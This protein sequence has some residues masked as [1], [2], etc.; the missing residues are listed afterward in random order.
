MRNTAFALAIA[1]AFVATPVFAQGIAPANADSGFFV[2]ANG[3]HSYFGNGRNS[4]SD[5]G[6]AVNGGYR[7]ALGSNF[8]L[9]PEIGYN[10]LGNIKINNVFTS[11]PVIKHGRSSLHG[12]TVGADAHYN[13][14]PHWYVSGRTGL[15]RWSGHG[16]TNELR[17]TNRHHN[18]NGYY[19]GVGVGYDFNRRLGVGIGY[20]Y[21]HAEKHQVNL[22]T[23]LLSAQLEYRF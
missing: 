22:T 17:P 6:F 18:A 14:N 10:D 9:G 20:D 12:W 11:H 15:Y 13:V 8:A 19:A 1:A 3:G 2:N 7:W 16:F 21:Y 4:G 23:R 5:T